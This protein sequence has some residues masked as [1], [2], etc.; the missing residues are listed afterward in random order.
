MCRV[1]SPGSEVQSE[2]LPLCIRH[3]L[4]DDVPHTH[5]ARE[6]AGWLTCYFPWVL[7]TPLVFWL[8]RKLTVNRAHG[9]RH[10]LLLIGAGLAVCYV[11][12]AI[13]V[14]VYAIEQ[15]AFGETISAS[16]RWWRLPSGE[17]AF[18]IALYFVALLAAWMIRT[19]IESQENER[20]AA[21][22]AVESQRLKPACASR[23][24]KCSACA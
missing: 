15:L 8:E 23:S 13:T 19:L 2:S 14:V 9:R 10:G 18:Q 7:L 24:W 6:L 21:Q 11:S 3:I 22:L 5:I 16:S 20:R 17:Y 12:A 4:L 1:S